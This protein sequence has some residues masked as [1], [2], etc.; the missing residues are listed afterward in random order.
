MKILITGSAG[1]IGSC[2][3]EYLKKKYNIF[4]TDKIIPKLQ[5]QKNFF[6]CN[7]LDFNK[8][9]KIIEGINPDIIIHLAAQSTVDF[10]KY[11]TNSL[12]RAEYEFNLKKTPFIVKRLFADR[13]EYWKLEDMIFPNL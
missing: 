12:D 7:L 6:L 4:G 10:P 13:Y 1:Y 5:K 2:L 9:N 11:L 3:F 8:I